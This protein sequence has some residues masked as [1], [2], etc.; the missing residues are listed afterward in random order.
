MAEKEIAANLWIA[1]EPKD[2]EY[3]RAA[4]VTKP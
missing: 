4:F 2:A 3:G 1:S